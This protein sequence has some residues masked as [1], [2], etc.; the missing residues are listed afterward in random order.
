MTLNSIKITCRTDAKRIE[1]WQG[2]G[3]RNCC[4]E[5]D[6]NARGGIKCEDATF[7]QGTK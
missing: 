5:T 6:D 1:N 7:G 2:L 3:K 4:N